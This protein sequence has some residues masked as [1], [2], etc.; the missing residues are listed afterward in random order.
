MD[1]V[2]FL[3]IL[4][5]SEESLLAKWKSPDTSAITAYVLEWKALCGMNPNHV[6][7]EI[8]DRNQTSFLAS[9]TVKIQI[10]LVFSLNLNECLFTINAKM[11]YLCIQIRSWTLHA[12]WNFS[13][14]KVWKWYWSALQHCGI[15]KAKR[16]IFTWKDITLI[17]DFPLVVFPWVH[18]THESIWYYYYF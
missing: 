2:P 12:L 18:A 4:P 14:S 8:V 15:H 11:N 6:S 3:K 9:G 1:P 10:I 5:Q 16:L 17:Q 7:F 13:V